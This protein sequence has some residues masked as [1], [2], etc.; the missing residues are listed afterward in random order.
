MPDLLCQY[1][2][3][4]LSLTCSYSP[5]PSKSRFLM[6]GQKVQ[7]F[8]GSQSNYFKKDPVV[9]MKSTNAYL[10]SAS[11]T[12]G[13]SNWSQD[14]ECR[15]WMDLIQSILLRMNRQLQHN[16]LI[17]LFPESLLLRTLLQV[18]FVF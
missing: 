10:T 5:C 7:R 14:V 2:H 4:D 12:Q 18:T 1:L 15:N 13:T 17:D 16:N 6:L 3:I 11:F 9:G 8:D